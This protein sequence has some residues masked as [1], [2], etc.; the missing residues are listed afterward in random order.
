MTLGVSGLP[1]AKPLFGETAWDNIRHKAACCGTPPGPRVPFRWLEAGQGWVT[2]YFT[3]VVSLDRQTKQLGRYRCQV[4][5]DGEQCPFE[6]DDE[7]ACCTCGPCWSVNTTVP[8]KMIDH[9]QLRHRITDPGIPLREWS[10]GLFEPEGCR[11]ALFCA[12]CTSSRQMLALSGIEDTASCGLSVFLCFQLCVPLLTRYRTV[13][14]NSINEGCVCTALVVCFCSFCSA[15]QTNRELG[16]AGVWPGS[17][18]GSFRP[19]YYGSKDLM[20]I[21]KAST[22]M[23]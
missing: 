22:T 14:L 12:S 18:C 21:T 1:R 15:A 19:A 2:K 3:D 9:V 8:V 11:E 6:I 17:S 16:H 13:K 5:S 10:T 4:R 20:P 23:A 7:Q